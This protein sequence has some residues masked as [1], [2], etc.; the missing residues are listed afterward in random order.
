MR[1][2]LVVSGVAYVLL[3]VAHLARMVAEG[4]EALAQPIF[5][6]TTL[7]AAMMT[8][9]SWRLFAQARRPAAR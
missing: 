8:L 3:L 5:L 1:A 4:I 6:S 2:Y 9:W 7:G